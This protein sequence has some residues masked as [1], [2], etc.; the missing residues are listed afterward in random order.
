MKKKKENKVKIGNKIRK[1]F[2][3]ILLK[4]I[5]PNSKLCNLRFQIN[6]VGV[7]SKEGKAE[8]E[9]LTFIGCKENF[10]V[11]MASIWLGRDCLLRSLVSF[12]LL[13]SF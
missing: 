10:G 8:G 4:S 12:L 1:Y 3:F 11:N 5:M 9:N 7:Y 13:I 6:L 2:L